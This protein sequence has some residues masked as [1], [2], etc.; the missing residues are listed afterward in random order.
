MG[1]LS[2]LFLIPKRARASG[3]EKGKKF[4]CAGGLSLGAGMMPACMLGYVRA[5]PTQFCDGHGR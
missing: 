2:I 5:E 4:F 1:S 3:R